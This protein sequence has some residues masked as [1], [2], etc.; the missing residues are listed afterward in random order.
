MTT[1]V[2]T[3]PRIFYSGSGLAAARPAAAS[4]GNGGLWFST[5]TKDIDQVQ[6]GAWET[7]FDYSL[8][9][10][11]VNIHAA[12]SD[13]HH[14]PGAK[15]ASGTYTGNN[16]ANRQI[17]TGFKCSLVICMSITL[18][19]NACWIV[20]PSIGAEIDTGNSSFYTAQMNRVLLHATD[21]FIVDDADTD[22]A[23]YNTE[24]YF[25]WAI[26]E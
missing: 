23:N 24:V 22:S 17:T 5:D 4:V 16:G 26:S 8:L 25:Y 21:G 6:S 11:S 10:T 7:I 20:I 3:I 18:T 15:V 12:I 9:L 1:E 2:T 14:S 13:A 19:P